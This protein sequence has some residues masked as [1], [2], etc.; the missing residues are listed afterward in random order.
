MPRYKV[1]FDDN[2][3][4]DVDCEG[5]DAEVRAHCATPSAAK[6]SGVAKQPDG[7]WPLKKIKTIAKV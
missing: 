1:T 5:G 6:R 7:T 2:T 3:T 4:Y